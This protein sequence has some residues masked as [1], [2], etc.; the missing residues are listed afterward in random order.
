FRAVRAAPRPAYTGTLA[1]AVGV[2]RVLEQ[3]EQA[4]GGVSELVGGVPPEKTPTV[5]G[6]RDTK[7]SGSADSSFGDSGQS[8]G[9]GEERS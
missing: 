4:Q 9:P 8:G 7:D 2:R 6:A 3:L 1:E 5:V